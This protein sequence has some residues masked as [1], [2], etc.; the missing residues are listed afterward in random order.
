MADELYRKAIVG[1]ADFVGEVCDERDC[2]MHEEFERDVEA[3]CKVAAW[4]KV[5]EATGADYATNAAELRGVVQRLQRISRDVAHEV[6]NMAAGVLYA[7]AEALE[8]E[9]LQKSRNVTDS[10]TKC[11][12]NV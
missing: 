5:R 7:V 8:A 11:D 4:G 2:T 6:S 9:R 12:D 1:N 3:E 10:V